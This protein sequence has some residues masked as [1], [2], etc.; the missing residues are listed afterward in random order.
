MKELSLKVYRES[1][2]SQ[3]N[4]GRY[5]P[6]SVIKPI[7]KGVKR[8]HVLPCGDSD[9]VSF[10]LEGE[11]VYC[12][13]ISHR[14]GYCGLTAYAPEDQERNESTEVFCQSEEQ[15]TELLGPRGLDLSERT[16]ANRLANYLAEVNC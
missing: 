4:A 15:Y 13:S 6:A 8:R 3:R 7:I 9:R 1:P 5:N 11:T 10:W 16:I 14:L 12:L 2:E